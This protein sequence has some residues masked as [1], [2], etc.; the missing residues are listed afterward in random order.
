MRVNASILNRSVFDFIYGF[1][2]ELGV[3][4]KVSRKKPYCQIFSGQ[5]MLKLY[6]LSWIQRFSDILLD[7]GRNILSTMMAMNPSPVT[8]HAVPKES[9]A[10]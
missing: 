10:M 3:S 1:I 2:P 9:I 7:L 6:V 8:L 5:Q 4:C